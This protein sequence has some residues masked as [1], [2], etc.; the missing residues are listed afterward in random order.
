MVHGAVFT[1]DVMGTDF[2]AGLRKS[3]KRLLAAGLSRM[4]NHNKIRFP[5]VEIGSAHPVYGCGNGIEIPGLLADDLCQSLYLFPV[6]F[7][8]CPVWM[9]R[10]AK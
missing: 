10:T 6:T 4:M 2:C 1:D 3:L 5:E 7:I 8:C 9:V